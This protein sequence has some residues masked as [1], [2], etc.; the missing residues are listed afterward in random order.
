VTFFSGASLRPVPRP[1]ERTRVTWISMRRPARRAQL[2]VGSSKRNCPANT[3]E[4]EVARCARGRQS[5]V[6]P[7]S[8][9]GLTS[10]RSVPRAA[11]PPSSSARR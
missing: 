2:P 10:C 7:L 11:D 8:W 4:R 1:P 3:C 6:C 5:G 9:H